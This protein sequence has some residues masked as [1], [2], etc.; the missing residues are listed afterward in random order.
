MRIFIKGASGSFCRALRALQNERNSHGNPIWRSRDKRE[1]H[2]TKKN[3]Q[4]FSDFAPR[5]GVTGRQMAARL[6]KL[7]YPDC[8]CQELHLAIAS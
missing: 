8:I 1:K 4:L 7:V 2:G 5:R 3:R 6:L